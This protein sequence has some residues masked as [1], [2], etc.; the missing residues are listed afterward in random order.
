MLKKFINT[1]VLCFVCFFPLLAE[2]V[3]D[4]T[5][6]YEMD[7]IVVSSRYESK[8]SLMGDDL[9]LR[10]LPQS[11]SVVNPM[12]IKDM[13]ITTIDQAMQ[14]V[15]GV[16]TIAND[17]MR[18]QYKSRGYSM[19]VMNDGLPSYNALAISQQLDLAFYEQVEVLRGPSGFFQGVPDGSSLGGIINLVKK[20]AEN[21]F[22]LN[23][24]SSVGSWQ[25][26]RTEVDLNAPILKNGCLNTRW[27]FM[28]N[29]REFFYDRSDATKIGVYGVIDWKATKTTL[30]SVSYAYQKSKGD[31]LYNGLPAIRETSEDN[32]RNHLDVDRAFNPTPD[33]DYTKWNTHEFSFLLDQ[34]LAQNWN[35]DVKLNW[36]G[37]TQEN[38]Y[39][40]A[41]T[42]TAL[43]TS[44]NYLRGYNDESIP[45]LS[46]A[47]NVFGKFNML[48]YEQNILLG[49]NFENFVDDKKY[50]SAYYKTQFGN[51]FLVQDFQVPYDKLNHSKMRV[52]QG[53]LYAQL[54]LVFVRNLKISLGGRL[55][56]LYAHMYDF[57]NSK[58]QEAIKDE[59]NF[60]PFAAIMY[61]TNPVTFYG[62]YSSIHV[63]QTLQREDGSML[64]PRKGHQAEIGAKSQFLNNK[65][66]FDLSLFYLIDDGRPYKVS[67]APAYI[68]GGRV[69]NKGLEFE[70][71]TY[72]YKGLEVI[73]SYTYLDTKITKS[74]D[75]DEGLAFSPIEPKHTFK[76]FGAYRFS[77]T[78]L[79][80]LSLGVNLM[81]FSESYASVLTPERNQPAYAILNAFISYD[82]KKYISLH[83][84]VN[85]ICDEV[86]YARL[87][88][89]GDYFGDPR[90]YTL[91]L[92]CNF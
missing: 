79:K 92:R 76:F 24:L 44:S 37:Q 77:E 54:R 6:V 39:G 33:W 55:G 7:E 13:N 26:F 53:G 83:F 35:L 9:P 62:S 88:G 84:N 32:S 47:A 17:Y 58:W 49:F 57:N 15:V 29:D 36:R 42:V 11:V 31:V 41:G 52:M 85:N 61:T 67:P 64:D 81:C 60:T 91:S 2:D 1:I 69:E 14:Y 80:G 5:M 4:T 27:V 89:N 30:L 43:D 78:V 16:T 10:S 3:L 66:N 45:R 51:P 25:N 23:T 20:H 90:N 48:G 22:Q 72:P 19:S 75:G 59:Y 34:K 50:L 87:G 73:A 56:S 63:P 38:K 70:A 21:K 12:R 68:N 65:L 74:S 82:F 46:G 86:Y 18:S 40:F 28:L 8:V 71:R